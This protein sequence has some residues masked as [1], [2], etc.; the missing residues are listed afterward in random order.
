[1]SDTRSDAP[2]KGAPGSVL[3]GRGV[4]QP[5]TLGPALLVALDQERKTRFLATWRQLVTDGSR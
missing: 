4:M 1:M 2:A 5:I 3:A